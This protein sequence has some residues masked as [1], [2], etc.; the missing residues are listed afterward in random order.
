MT[1]YILAL[2]LSPVRFPVAAFMRALEFDE[3]LDFLLRGGTQ[4]AQ[5]VEHRLHAVPFLEKVADAQ[6][7]RLQD[8]QQRIQADLVFALLHARQVGLMNTDPVRK[9]DLCQFALTAELPD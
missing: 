9:L 7:E 8:F 4:R 3:A 5:F 6:I 2:A 1:S